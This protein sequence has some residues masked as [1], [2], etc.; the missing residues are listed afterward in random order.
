MPMCMKSGTAAKKE[1][2]AQ[3][4]FAKNRLVNPR[5]DSRFNFKN[6]SSK[7]K[8]EFK[9]SNVFS[10]YF[11]S[12]NSREEVLAEIRVLEEIDHK[13]VL[14]FVEG[15]K[16]WSL[17][18]SCHERKFIFLMVRQLFRIP[19]NVGLP[20]FHKRKGKRKD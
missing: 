11:G 8:R 19:K 20:H 9:P 10:G 18:S 6:F 16:G 12:S 3:K 14:K 5:V 13:F 1:K 4:M 7:I 15:F 2:L 17:S